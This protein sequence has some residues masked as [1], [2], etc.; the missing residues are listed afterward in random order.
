MTADP[1]AAAREAWIA[2]PFPE[3]SATDEDA[4]DLKSDLAYWDYIVADTVL[5]FVNGGGWREPPVD[6]RSG[7]GDMRKRTQELAGR[8]K[9]DEVDRVRR[10]E[11]YI[12]L[13]ATVYDEAESAARR[14]RP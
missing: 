5:P 3:G 10:Y 13:L 1:F 7:I 9:S 11:D 6:V 4:D 8:A 2:A 12:T 14:E